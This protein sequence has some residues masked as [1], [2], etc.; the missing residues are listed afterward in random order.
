MLR[1]SKAENVEQHSSDLVLGAVG[2]EQHRQQGPHGILHLHTVHIRAHCQVLHGDT[3][4]DDLNLVNRI[5]SAGWWVLRLSGTGQ[6]G[7]GFLSQ[8][9]AVDQNCNDVL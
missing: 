4:L 1:T 2:V 3:V 8:N 6:R 7:A 5:S 9:L